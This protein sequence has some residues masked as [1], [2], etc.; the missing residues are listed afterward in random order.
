MTATAPGQG[1]TPAGDCDTEKVPEGQALLRI[2]RV[3][4]VMMADAHTPSHKH[5]RPDHGDEPE[6]DELGLLHPGSEYAAYDIVQDEDDRHCGDR[7][8]DREK[9]PDDEAVPQICFVRQEERSHDGLSMSGT[10]GVKNPIRQGEGD[11]KEQ[12]GEGARFTQCPGH[13]RK[14]LVEALLDR[15][16]AKA[17]PGED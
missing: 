17:D 4:V 15:T 8:D 9:V 7:V 12:A 3:V 14:A 1:M 11:H 2:D 13:S 10:G 6:G 5:H 16:N